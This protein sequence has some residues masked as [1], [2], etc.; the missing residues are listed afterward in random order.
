MDGNYNANNVY[1]DSDFIFTENIGT[2]EIPSAGNIEVK[3]EGMSM[4]EFFSSLFAEEKNPETIPPSATIILSPSTTKYEVGSICTPKYKII[5]NE[6][7]YTYGPLTEVKASHE[8]KDSN[9]VTKNDE[10]GE[11]D[12]FIVSDTTNYYISANITYTNGQVPVTNLGNSYVEGQISEGAL[13][14]IKTASITGYRKCFYGTLQEKGILDSS[15]IRNLNKSTSEP[16]TNGSTFVINIPVGALRVVIAYPATIKNMDSVLDKNDS[17]S[18]IV[19][20]FGDPEI[21]KVKGANDFDPIDYKVYT[22]DF[23]NPY[24]TTNVFT[25]TI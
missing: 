11:F 13:E 22:M 7:S 1:F 3:A 9:G 4:K 14:E 20:G 6:G 24:N 10:I 23:A 16:L 2:V 8:V 5:F 15:V 21:I 18:N 25:V 12:S 19:S 17:N